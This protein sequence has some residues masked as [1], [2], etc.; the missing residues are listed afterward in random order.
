MKFVIIP[1]VVAL[2]AIAACGKKKTRQCQK[3]IVERNTSSVSKCINH[4]MSSSGLKKTPTESVA[5]GGYNK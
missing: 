1:F 2:L 4:V 5:T 3:S